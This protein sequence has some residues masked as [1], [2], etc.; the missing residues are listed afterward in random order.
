MTNF[1]RTA[2]WLAACGK[3]VGNPQHFS[4]QLGVHLEEIVETL[5]CIE[6]N[7][8][9]KGAE[10]IG[11]A[12][13]T[14]KEL[15]TQLKT[16]DKMARIADGKAVDFLDG[17]CDCEV[18]GNAVAFLAGFD[19][20]GADQEVLASNES[21]LVNGRPVFLP[22]GKIGKPDSYQPPRLDQFINGAKS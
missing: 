21:K 12:I 8:G 22:G 13:G 11:R 17:L 7:H 2:D 1:K 14:F 5:T 4:V 9:P 15:A 18:T 6:T 19:K 3:Q 10:L 20:D 16:G